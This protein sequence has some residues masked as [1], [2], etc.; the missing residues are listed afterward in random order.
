MKKLLN[1]LLV[2]TF[3]IGFT[4]SI[5]TTVGAADA[6]MS[7]NG[8]NYSD[9]GSGWSEAVKLAYDGDDVTVKLFADWTANTSSGFTTVDGVGVQDGALYFS[10]IEGF[11][12]DLNGYTIDRNAPEGAA[13]SSVFVVKNSTFT[14]TDTSAAK[15]GKITGGN[16]KNGG[17]INALRCT[18][19]VNGGNIT[20][21]KASN[22]GGGIYVDGGE[23]HID[24]GTVSENVATSYGGGVY[25]N[26]CFATMLSG[27]VCGNEA[28]YGGGVYLNDADFDMRGGDISDNK[29]HDGGGV[30]LYSDTF[31]LY[32]GV[33]ARNS[34]T[35]DGGGVFSYDTFIMNGGEISE[36]YAGSCGGGA[37][38]EFNKS[39]EMNGGTFA[40]NTAGWH[41]GAISS[42]T[43]NRRANT[44][45]KLDI[46]EGTF[47]GNTAMEGSGGAI[48]WY[49]GRAYLVNCTIT[50]NSAPNGYGGGFFRLYDASSFLAVG[51]TCNI[52]G[53]TA[54]TDGVDNNS[55]IYSSSPANMKIFSV[56]ESP[57][58]ADSKIGV[59]F[60]YPY[61]NSYFSGG[62]DGIVNFGFS[63]E[64]ADC[65]VSDD[66]SFKVAKKATSNGFYG[67][68][69]IENPDPSHMGDPVFIIETKEGG[70]K[71]Y[72]NRKQGWLYALEQSKTT[73]VK[74]TLNADWKARKGNFDYGAAG[75]TGGAL[76]ISDD[77]THNIT[78]D[79][80][81]YTIDRGLTQ[82]VENGL[83]FYIDTYGSLT[84]MDSSEEQTG[85]ITG[86]YNSTEY[87]FAD[88]F[89]GAF[90][91]DYGTLYIK[92][93]NI[94]GNIAEYGAGIYCDDQDDASVYI[95]GG[96][97]FGN[98]AIVD[99]GGIFM[100]NGYLYV[101]GG[102]I[103]GNKAQNGAGVYWTS[104]NAAYFVGG[105][106]YG[107]S[108]NGTAGGGV[109]AANYG[110]IYLGGDVMIT[111][112]P[113]G[114]NLYLAS[115]NVDINNACGQDGAPNKP[116][117]EGARIGISA[118]TVNDEISEDGSMFDEG[119]IKYLYADRD[120]NVIRAVYDPDDADH[121]YKLYI[122]EKTHAD[123]RNP[124]VKKVSVVATGILEGATLDY[125][126]QT[127]TLIAKNTKKHF[128]ESMSLDLLISCTYDENTY[129]LDK[130]DYV[131]DFSE[132]QEYKIMSDNGT[133]VMC[134]VIV[135]PEGGE[136]AEN[137]DSVENAYKMIVKTGASGKA[138]TDFGEGWAYAV[139]QSE[140]VTVVLFDDWTAKDGKF[141]YSAGTNKGRLYVDGKDITIDLNGHTI[142]RGLTTETSD[143]QVFRM[144]GGAIL[145]INDSSEDGNGKITGGFNDGNGGGFYI[146]YGK[147][148]INGGQITGNKADNGAGIYATNEDD[149][150][151]YINGG[152]I[153]GNTAEVSGGG[154][155]MYNGYLYVD[156]GEISGNTASENG[157]AIYWE[158]RDKLCLT[159]GKIINN[160]SYHGAGVYVTDWGDIY[161][162]GNIV[163]KDNLTTT[164]IVFYDLF[165]SDED[166]MINH[167]VG[168]DSDVPNKPFTEGACV[169]ITTNDKTGYCI[170]G[171]DSRFYMDS[172]QYLKASTVFDYVCAE[173]DV[174]GGNHKY[175]IYYND[176]NGSKKYP[177]I[178]SVTPKNS[179]IK[180]ASVDTES[181]VITIAAYEEARKQG[182]FKNVK[183]SSLIDATF[184]LDGAR[185][186]GY[187]N[188][189]DFTNEQKFMII[190]DDNKYTIYSVKVEFVERTSV[191]IDMGEK[192]AE[193]NV[194]YVEINGIQ[195]PVTEN[196]D[197][198][199]DLVP[200]GNAIVE[201][202]EKESEN[203]A[204]TVASSYYYV[205]A[206][207]KTY[208]KLSLDSYMSAED[209]N[210]IRLKE[211]IGIR[212][213]SSAS[214][215]SKDELDEYVIDEIGFIV[216]VTE[217]LGE[218]ELTLDFA[219]YV[220]GVAY[221]R[222]ENK[223]IVFDNSNDKYDVFS[224]VLLNVPASQ[225]KTNLTCKTYTKITV[226]GQQFVLYG[227]AVTG[228]IYDT[229]KAALEN[230]P[231][232][233]ALLKIIFDADGTIGI[234][235][236]SLYD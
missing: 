145:T 79:L 192:K 122:N 83:V 88:S 125:D 124:R 112:N 46:K 211:P 134:K 61:T 100:E 188:V 132:P 157:G 48:F 23:C 165:L 207:T 65:F 201:I 80:N 64:A 154:I 172:I 181:Q 131:R 22:N 98:T 109:Y 58:K 138:F 17:G 28:E 221:N 53:N 147:L 45:F 151:V 91:V 220:K 117:T 67:V 74:I 232:N 27:S 135:V 197:N 149:S 107:N 42:I 120:F 71:E 77:C 184:D 11:T 106:I 143:G 93:G 219:K 148:Y 81:G 169:R 103:T 90:H 196:T 234:S 156:G 56:G 49:E 236:D 233:E 159:G 25:I 75:S 166:V 213:K 111:S 51:G 229:V 19:N 228:N 108:A 167:A 114:G 38:F 30:Y 160:T 110:E 82:P 70:R 4:L 123:T 190:G 193:S 152:K 8:Y 16:A 34:A 6:V 231:G 63:S 175:K 206:K 140:S 104:D 142:D 9:H 203:A 150:F 209:D 10:G 161:L 177:I 1:L 69:L 128:F 39:F 36:N 33:I 182:S 31:D 105:K 18:L 113:L 26:N 12:L 87:A 141:D 218:T 126:T 35:S 225:Y 97:I 153:C 127:I 191:E 179:L 85:T 174:N 50:G 3:V 185:I 118:A 144:A 130:M 217:Q 215:S 29:A 60:G 94:T 32:D 92:G 230:D 133:Y 24:G 176:N 86:A 44:F 89:G 178:Q 195:T 76:Y 57:L 95:Q 163:I 41:G 84:I 171:S 129:Y 72:Y 168:Q 52:T 186:E 43:D 216:A 205:D 204:E 223:D 139:S 137:Q 54:Y 5:A 224:G 40:G 55:N 170:S 155:Y 20:G 180:S 194:R 208:K 101:E 68:Y 15:T 187:N 102:E 59:S 119:D 164:R 158:S 198:I 115:S 199:Y 96:K 226:N 210:T 227:E 235:L 162:G 99:G 37:Y 78:I 21:N 73:D 116:L 121:R 200:S 189:C 47:T 13:S 7:V 14:I 202:I 212:F 146:D 66:P 183:L 2:L 173:Y 62:G 136:W 214:T 222:S